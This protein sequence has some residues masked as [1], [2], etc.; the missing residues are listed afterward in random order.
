MASAAPPHPF[1]R[2]ERTGAVP[3]LSAAELRAALD[4][5]DPP[6]VVDVRRPTEGRFGGL[7]RAVRIPFPD[8]PDRLRDLPAGRPVVVVDRSGMDA[9]RAAALLVA[10][11]LSAAALEGG[12]DEYARLEDPTVPRFPADDDEGTLLLVQWPRPETG[13]LAYLVADPGSGDAVVIDPGLA[14]APYEAFLRD[15]GLN[16]RAVVETHTHADHL[17]GHAPLHQRSGAPILVGR[18]SPAAYPH[19]DLAEGDAV[20]FGDQAIEVLET[21]G[22]TMDHLSLHVG[23]HVFTGDTLLLGSVGRTDLGGGD[24]DRLRESLLEKLLRLPPETEVLPAH[25]GPRQGLPDRYSSTIGFERGT[26][27]ALLL[28]SAEAFRRYMTEG[29]PPKPADFDR[30]VATNV[31]AF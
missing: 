15:H 30:I 28:P 18:R 9:R 22:H 5:P 21:P 8:L 6:T 10:R 24:P 14:V 29:W 4:G 7:P 3:L 19:V 25:F 2:P 12:L 11:G 26:N 31:A 17:A 20:E 16:L 27:E 1:V 23:D 13:C